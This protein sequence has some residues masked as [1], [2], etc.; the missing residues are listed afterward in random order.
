[1]RN[2]AFFFVRGIVS[3]KGPTLVFF[4]FVVFFGQ[5]ISK[6]GG[7]RRELDVG[8][9]ARN[10]MEGAICSS[11]EITWLV[12]LAFVAFLCDFWRV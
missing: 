3:F 12:V 2:G 11:F 7:V 9:M 6:I 1:M 5:D 4:A 10:K 8:Y